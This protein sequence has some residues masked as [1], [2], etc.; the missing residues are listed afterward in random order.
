MILVHIFFG[1]KKK[2]LTRRIISFLF[3]LDWLFH[4][5]RMWETLRPAVSKKKEVGNN[6]RKTNLFACL[7]SFVHVC[8]CSSKKI[9]MSRLGDVLMENNWNMFC[10]SPHTC[11]FKSMFDLPWEKIRLIWKN[12]NWHPYRSLGTKTW[13]PWNMMMWSRCTGMIGN[14]APAALYHSVLRSWTGNIFLSKVEIH[15]FLHWKCVLLQSLQKANFNPCLTISNLISLE[16]I[17]FNSYPK[18]QKALDKTMFKS[19]STSNSLHKAV[20][21]KINM[22]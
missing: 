4:L 2:F 10:K 11:G 15:H 8:T 16:V 6:L 18:R 5:L 21:W 14:W 17:P 13:S 20:W 7:A 9:N 22:Q 1:R 12:D 19:K 3:L